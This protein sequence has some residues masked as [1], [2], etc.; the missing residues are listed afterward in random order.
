MTIPHGG[1]YVL[2]SAW[3]VL[4]FCAIVAIIVIKKLGKR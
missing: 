4:V 2:T 3:F 1:F